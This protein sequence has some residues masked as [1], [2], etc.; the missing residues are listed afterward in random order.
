MFLEI[1]GDMAALIKAMILRRGSVVKALPSLWKYGIEYLGED[2]FHCIN[3]ESR[4]SGR[5]AK[6]RLL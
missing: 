6:M 4:F 1:K 2:R 5:K 3:K